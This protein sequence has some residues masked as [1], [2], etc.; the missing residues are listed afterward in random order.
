MLQDPQRKSLIR[1]FKIY[2]I[3]PLI[4]TCLLGVSL[5]HYLGGNLDLINIVLGIIICLLMFAMRLFL[6]AYFDHPDSLTSTLSREDEQWEILKKVKRSMLLQYSLLVLAAGAAV[7]V[8]LISRQA[9]STPGLLFLGLTLLGYFFCAT[10]PLRLDRSG[11]GDLVEGVVTVNLVPAFLVSLQ[12]MDVPVLLLQLT[13]PLF[14][15]YMAAKIMFAFREYGFDSMHGRRS[16]VTLIGW[17]NSVLLHNVFILGAFVLVGAFLLGGVPWSLSWP[18]LIVLPMG[19]FQVWQLLRV[20]DGGK[21]VWKLLLWTA[22][23]LV[24]LMAYLIQVPLWS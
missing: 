23:G 16:L 18:V 5:V 19:I 15:I 2:W 24:L 20:S 11:Y 14:L 10:P 13:L 6:N 21:P 7:T 17:K 4:F 3:I 12:K 9:L 8:I 1:I 22:M